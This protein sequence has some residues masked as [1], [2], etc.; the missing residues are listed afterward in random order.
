MALAAHVVDERHDQRLQGL[1]S[2][3]K[4]VEALRKISL[5]SR[6]R[7]FSAFNR[8]IS[9]DSLLEVPGR[10]PGVDLGLDHPAPHRLLAETKLIGDDLRDRG[11]RRIVRLVLSE[12]R[13]R[14]ILQGR[15]TLLSM[16]SSSWTQKEAASNP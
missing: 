5:S 10:A 8:L 2:P 6:S 15:V 9:A 11:H 13:K 1:S 4:K 7:R 14:P 12:Q 16:C 3:A